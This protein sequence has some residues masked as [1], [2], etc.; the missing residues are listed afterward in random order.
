MTCHEARNPGFA[1]PLGS[2]LR[3][4][5]RLPHMSSCCHTVTLVA[6]CPADIRADHGPTTDWR[7]T[8][9]TLDTAPAHLPVFQCRKGVGSMRDADAQRPSAGPAPWMQRGLPVRSGRSRPQE[10][11][12]NDEEKHLPPTC[13]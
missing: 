7:A 8:S 6:V 10:G 13:Q 5:M 11:K 3:S 1:G 9:G 12:K 2:H 4:P